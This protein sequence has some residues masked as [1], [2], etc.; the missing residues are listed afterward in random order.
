MK[1]D[2]V[3]DY[4]KNGL[5]VSCQARKGWPMYGKEIMAAFA[6]AAVQGG[7]V[8][9]RATDP[10]NIREIK[11]KVDVPIIGI[12]KQWI[13]GYDVYITPTFS[14]AEEIISAGADIVALDGTKRK[15]PY[16]E[17]LESIIN[18]I[19]S[20]YPNILI[21]ADC[22]NLDSALYS[23]ESG[24]DILSTTLTGYTDETKNISHFDIE[25]VSSFV[26]NINLPII[27]EGRIYTSNDLIKAFE[28]GVHSAVI[29][30]IITRPDFITSQF[31]KSLKEYFE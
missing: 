21:M 11:N 3:L 14:S 20:K 19:K 28:V 31:T 2:D 6:D 12:Y 24:A 5:I 27:A 1:K 30:S 18:Q 22:D 10:E 29:G 9:I 25:T 8:G 16:N 17:S 13:H 23:K 7:A 15:R 26:N 4:I